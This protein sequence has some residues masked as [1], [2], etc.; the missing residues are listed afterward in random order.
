MLTKKQL[1]KKVRTLKGEPK[2]LIKYFRKHEDDVMTLGTSTIL[3]SLVMLQPAES[4]MVTIGI[5]DI[6]GIAAADKYFQMRKRGKKILR[7]VI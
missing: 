6:I 2:K 3:G 5:A 4:T 7:K 1:Y